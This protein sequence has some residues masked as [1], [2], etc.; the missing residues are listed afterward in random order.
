MLSAPRR[1]EAVPNPTGEWAIFSASS[2]S[3]E[4]KESS[5]NWN[6]LNLKNGTIGS[7]DVFT[8]DVS[9]VVWIPGSTTEVIYINGTNEEAA[10]GVT[11]WLGDL[12][13][14]LSFKLVASLPGPFS[15]LK[16]S[17]TASG[18]LK[19]LVNA[20][21][22]PNGTVYNAETASKPRSTGRLYSDTFVRHWDFWLT[23]E[24]YTLFSG[25]L[26]SKGNYALSQ[27]GVQNLLIN[28]NYT[29]TRPETP[30]Q[31]FGDDGDYD[32]SPDGKWVAFLSKA[33]ELAKANYTASYIYLVPF[34]SPEVAPIAINGP[35]TAAQGIGALG[36]S[37]GPRFSP[38]SSKIAF[39]Q[40]DGISY[41][42]DK[43]KVYVTAV[44]NSPS[45]GGE[46]SAIAGDWD[47]S[48]DSLAWNPDGKS[49]FVSASDLGEEKLFTLPITAPPNYEPR[50]FTAAGTNVAW[51]HIL[52]DSSAL[53]SGNS[54]WSSRDFYIKSANATKL[55]FSATT[56]DP[57]LEGLSS[58]DVEQFYF[59]GALGIPIQSWIIKPKGFQA[60]GTYPLAFIVHGG[61]QGGHYNSW[62]TRW[63]FKVFADQG[64]VVIAPNPTGSSGWGQFLQDSIQNQWGG[65]PY[66]DLV[67]CWDYIEANLTYIDTDRAVELGASYGGYMTNWIQGHDLGRKFKALVAHDGLASTL[68][69]Y[70]TEELW[71]TQH[72]YNGT[73]WDNRENYEIW[74][75]AAHIKNF[76][77]PQFIIHS[78]EDYRL[79]ESEGIAMFNYLQSRGVPSRFLSFPDEDHWVLKPENSLQ[80]HKNVLGW[81]NHYSGIG[82]PLSDNAIGG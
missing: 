6:L 8:E 23:A 50:K 5:S 51:F 54:I 21:A 73:L 43:S 38:D 48:V 37:G 42:S 60:N 71:F 70:A 44:K 39:W 65:H 78:A 82:G 12:F 63:N 11:L 34:D 33:P 76:S 4:K 72:E 27:A 69:A 31:P 68:G 67:K 10:G 30:V 22:Y 32:L 47:R 81:I 66:D 2:Y 16:V 40:Q 57:E 36:A 52:S 45:Y 41:E 28:L 79:P 46:W 9:E 25:T 49:L 18:D 14:L 20:L 62:S 26:Q 35:D 15:G 80:W 53:V 77:T 58:D 3:F 56:T 24:R 1:S 55:L 19:F 13:E 61:P 64:Y 59:T 17:K 75:P 74:D 29:V 7:L